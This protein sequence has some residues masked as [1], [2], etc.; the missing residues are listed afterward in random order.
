MDLITIRISEQVDATTEADTEVSQQS[1]FL[2]GIAKF[3]NAESTIERKNSGLDTAELI[4]ATASSQFTGEGDTTRKGDFTASLSAMVVEVLPSGVIRV[5]GKRIMTVNNE[6]QT[7]LVTGLVRPRDINSQNE[8]ESNKVANLR[9]DLF[10][11]GAVGSAQTGGW[12][13]NTLREYWP[14]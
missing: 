6:E 13:G 9:V 2:A 1:N 7:L 4:D 14:F 8:V 10:G 3:F 12:L 11:N 5:E